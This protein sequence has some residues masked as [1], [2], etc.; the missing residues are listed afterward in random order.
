MNNLARFALSAAQGI[1]K[2]VPKRG[3]PPHEGI[4]P[5]TEQVLS[6]S[7]VRGTRG[8][9]E[10]IVL[11]VN[12]CYERGWFDGCAVMIR[13][14]IETLIIEAFEHYKI[15]HKIQNR[16]GDFFYLLML[17]GKRLEE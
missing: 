14:L 3:K 1:Q 11:Q 10:K 2:E 13:R 8:Y 17:R 15:A 5:E 7:L 9:I 4:T 12:G 6:H 16:N